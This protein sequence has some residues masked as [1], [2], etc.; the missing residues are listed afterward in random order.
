M[1]LVADYNTKCSGTQQLLLGCEPNL[2]SYVRLYSLLRSKTH[3]Y[4]GV[5]NC[6]V[7]LRSTGLQN[8]F[9]QLRDQKAFEASIKGA[10]GHYA[11]GQH[12]VNRSVTSV[13]VALLIELTSNDGQVSMGK[14]RT[15]SLFLHHHRR[16]SP[17]ISTGIITTGWQTSSRSEWHTCRQ[18]ALE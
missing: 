2:Q 4:D 17:P 18:A 3:E 15:Q 13:Y 5:L 6:A 1:R 7:D 16:N 8:P 9:P 10:H 14:V 12:G 11:A